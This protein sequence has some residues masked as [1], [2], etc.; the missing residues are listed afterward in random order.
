M[1][2]MPE[3]THSYPITTSLLNAVFVCI[4]QRKEHKNIQIACMKYV[5]VLEETNVVMNDFVS[6]CRYV[7]FCSFLFMLWHSYIPLHFICTCSTHFSFWGNAPTK[8][9]CAIRARRQHPPL[10]TCTRVHKWRRSVEEPHF[11]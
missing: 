6:W 4:R 11:Y 3:L 7:S 8:S 5:V 2:T 10:C 9:L 1:L